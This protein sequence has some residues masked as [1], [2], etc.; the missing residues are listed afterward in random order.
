MAD[1]P[2][3]L[4]I[5]PLLPTAQNRNYIIGFLSRVSQDLIKGS[6]TEHASALWIL[7]VPLQRGDDLV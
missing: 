7:M 3:R 6:L 5:K 1:L 2:L 4:T